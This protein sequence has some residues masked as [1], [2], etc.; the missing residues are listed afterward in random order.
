MKRY[1]IWMI[2]ILAAVSAIWIQA[3]LHGYDAGDHTLPPK[4][5]LEW[6]D[7]FTKDNT[8]LV[9]PDRIDYPSTHESQ[10]TP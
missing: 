8:T 1:W 3:E 5:R 4:A 2:P 10:P 6:R 9:T 7:N